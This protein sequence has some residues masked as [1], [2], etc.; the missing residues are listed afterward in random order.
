[1]IKSGPKKLKIYETLTG[2]R[3]YSEWLNKLRDAM[4][5]ARI[6]VR[7]DRIESGNLGHY[8]ALG[9]SLFEFKFDFGPG[10]RVYFAVEGDEIILLLSG[11]D[12]GTQRKDITRARE[13]FA[14]YT[15]RNKK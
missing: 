14:D 8:R 7:I 9:D 1:V 11:G 15:I 12:K 13:Y 3:P 10:Y 5:V 2:A 4:I 6:R